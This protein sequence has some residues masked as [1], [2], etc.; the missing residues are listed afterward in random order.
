VADLLA[1]Y[2]RDHLAGASL[3]TE[4]ARR[5]A[6]SN[7][8]TELGAFLEEL[9]DEID[10][11]R[12]ALL[13]VFEIAGLRPSRMKMGAAWALEKVGRMK[14]NGRLVRYSPLSRLLELEGLTMGIAAKRS[15]WQSLGEIARDE[16][17]LG[18]FDFAALEGRAA[19]QLEALEPHRRAAAR[20]AL[21][22]A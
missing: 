4:L 9:A 18:G 8:G 15:L 13:Q 19:A 1:I 10:A 3:G 5:A 6:R 17:R 11:D 22:S 14:L 16:P 20:G 7:R 2:L 12:R 21:V